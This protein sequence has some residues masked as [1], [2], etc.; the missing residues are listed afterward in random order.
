MFHAGFVSGTFLAVTLVLRS[1]GYGLSLSDWLPA[2]WGRPTDALDLLDVLIHLCTLSS[3]M[4]D[5]LL[6]DLDLSLYSVGL[7]IQHM[8]TVVGCLECLRVPVGKGYV[9]LNNFSA[10]LGSFVYCFYYV[11]PQV[12]TAI[13]YVAGMTFSN[14]FCFY[15]TMQYQAL[16]HSRGENPWLFVTLFYILVVLRQYP[17]FEFLVTRNWMTA[18]GNSKIATRNSKPGYG[19][20]ALGGGRAAVVTAG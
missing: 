8:T 12:W 10:F 13:T 3:E 1:L 5:S 11:R 20:T 2:P 18:A 17:V 14:A 19:K 15:M 16:M 4:K 6:V 9:T 7:F